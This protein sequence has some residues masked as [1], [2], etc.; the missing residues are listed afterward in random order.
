M[1]NKS[2]GTAFEK[3]LA[4]WLSE[5]GFWVHRM[6]DNQNGQPFD[7]LA[8]KNGETYVIDCKDCNG[9][10]FRLSRIEENQRT[11]MR[12]WQETGNREGLFA[13]RFQNQIYLAGFQWL[14]HLRK[15]GR[16]QVQEEDCKN[17]GEEALSWINKRWK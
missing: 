14:E 10:I 2:K 8:A 12:L 4:Q 9:K 15:T 5:K 17:Y 16:K 11:A 13:I 3:E 7:L 1:N 6:Q